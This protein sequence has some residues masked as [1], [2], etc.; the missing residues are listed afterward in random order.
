[1]WN[2][3]IELIL[4]D[5]KSMLIF[6]N[7]FKTVRSV[8]VKIINIHDFIT[9]FLKA[10]FWKCHS[11]CVNAFI[12]NCLLA[13]SEFTLLIIQAVKSLW[14]QHDPFQIKI[15][16]I[17]SGV[18][19]MCGIFLIFFFVCSLT[20]ELRF[21]VEIYKNN[22]SDIIRDKIDLLPQ[23]IELSGTVKNEEKQK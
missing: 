14:A 12:G 7:K 3:L 22:K 11:L 19:S 13:W 1:M 9:M 5:L 2:I 16:L 6:L 20:F 21:T 23:L 17:C 8:L 15:L 4:D 18:V 10:S